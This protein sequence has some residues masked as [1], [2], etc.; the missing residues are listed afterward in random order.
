M[1][2]CWFRVRWPRE[3][4]E[5]EALQ[6]SFSLRRLLGAVLELHGRHGELAHH[7]GLASGQADQFVREMSAVLPALMLEALPERPT[8]PVTPTVWRLTRRQALPLALDRLESTNRS[9]LSAFASLRPHEDM[10]L[11]WAFGRPLA[12]ARLPQAATDA[13]G[14][15]WLGALARA[16][17][18]G[19]DKLPA[20]E[21][22]RL[23]ESGR[24]PAGA[25]PAAS[26]F[27]P[28]RRAVPGSWLLP[29]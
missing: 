4:S 6:F 26:V 21:R 19:S 28:I 20:T 1:N 29:S 17:F 11:Q 7:L 12:P 9:V 8:L 10:V 22:R 5:E 16:P 23:Q 15:S 3:L 27:R 13:P 14:D 25:S 18:M 2:R 24:Y